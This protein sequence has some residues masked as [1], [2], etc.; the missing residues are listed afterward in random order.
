M[1]QCES[2]EPRAD[3]MIIHDSLLLTTVTYCNCLLLWLLFSGIWR[4]RRGDYSTAISSNSNIS[5]K[6]HILAILRHCRWSVERRWFA[7]LHNF[8]GLLPGALGHCPCDS[9]SERI[10]QSSLQKFKRPAGP[11]HVK[12]G[13]T[14]WTCHGSSQFHSWNEEDCWPKP[15]VE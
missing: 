3:L 13:P 2:F 9:S 14:K 15:Y 12:D 4:V 7:L 10:S 5:N 11:M 6:I 8:Q 1:N